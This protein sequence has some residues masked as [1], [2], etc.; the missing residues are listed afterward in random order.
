MVSSGAGKG[1]VA[2]VGHFGGN[3]GFFQQVQHAV[4]A[5]KHLHQVGGQ[6]GQRHH[7]AKGPQR[8]QRADQHGFP[9]DC[10]VPAQ[11]KRG[12]QHSQGG[13]QDD[14]VGHGRGQALA[15]LHGRLLF[16]QGFAVGGNP[17]GAGGGIVILDGLPQAA[18][19]FQHIAVGIGQGG[20]VFA[21]RGFALALRPNGDANAHSQVARQQHKGRQRMVPRHKAHHTGAAQHRNTHGGNGVGI[22]Y[23]QLFNVCRNQRDQIT[24]VAAFQLGGGQAAQS[25]KHLIPDQG[26]QLEGDKMV[27]CL[28]CI[29]QHTAQQGKH[30]HAGKRGACRGNGGRQPCRAQN[31]KPS[32]DGD[33]GGAE[34]P[35]HA[36]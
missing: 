10:T 29:A 36:H 18:Q 14:G 31:G 4:R 5:G 17:G 1:G 3:G 22:K 21:A 33:K 13:K 2:A 11:H 6:V 19:A 20:A 32:K 8:R 35:R 30:Q 28:L 25:T 34:I 7:R 12:A 24:T 26:Q 15:A 23:F 9:A 27:G 16:A